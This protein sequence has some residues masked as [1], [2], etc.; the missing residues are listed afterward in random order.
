VLSVTHTKARAATFKAFRLGGLVAFLFAVVVVASWAGDHDG[1]VAVVGAASE[2]EYEQRK[3]S[4]H[5]ASLVM[6]L[7]AWTYGGAAA[8]F[9]IFLGRIGTALHLAGFVVPSPHE[10]AALTVLARGGAAYGGEG[11]ERDADSLHTSSVR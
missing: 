9:L 11:Y 6:P 7:P 3:E 5:R 8:L 1:V 4:L 10:E 2:Q